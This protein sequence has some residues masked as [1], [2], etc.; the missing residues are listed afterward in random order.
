MVTAFQ[1]ALSHEKRR[2][3]DLVAGEHRGSGGRSVRDR[4][5]EIR[6]AAGLKAGAHGGKR[7]AARH[8]IVGKRRHLGSGRRISH[9]A[10]TLSRVRK[11]VHRRGLEKSPFPA[12]QLEMTNWFAEANFSKNAPVGYLPGNI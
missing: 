4:A 8:L 9:V 5:G 1:V 11:I 3:H 2:G 6:I 12:K 7:K 10:F